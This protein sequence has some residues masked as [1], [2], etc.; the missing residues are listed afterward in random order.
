MQV[1]PEKELNVFYC[2]AREDQSL[3]QKLEQHLSNLKRLYHL[4]TWFDR[5]ILPGDNWAE[6]IEKN[7][8]SADLILLLISPDFMAS[9]YCYSQEMKRA[10]TRHAQG[11]VR[12]IPILLRPVHW[13][14]A[15]FSFIQMLPKDALPVTLWLNLDEAFYDIVL[16]IEKVI[17]NLLSAHETKEVPGE[18]ASEKP[19]FAYQAE[20]AI[21]TRDEWIDEGD[22]FYIAGQYE[23]ALSSY[24]Q[25]NSLASEDIIISLKKGDTLHKLE[26]Y[27]EA[28]QAYAQ[29]IRLSP[30]LAMKSPYKGDALID[31]QVAEEAL[32]LESDSTAIYRNKISALL[33]LQ[34][35][36]EALLVSEQITRPNFAVIA[37]D[38]SNKAYALNGLKRYDQALL[39]CE[40]AIRLKPRL[41]IAYK[42]KAYT[43][44][45]LKRY[46]E[47]LQACEQVIQLNPTLAPAYAIM[48]IVLFRLKSYQEASTAFAQWSEYFSLE[49]SQVQHP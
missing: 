48:G 14:N 40:Q 32:L 21:K 15:P 6:V 17:K 24:E 2:Y 7:L 29:A 47:A 31:L 3:S 5:Q 13:K 10:L 34:R 27:R 42:N 28:I 16:G 1:S 49:T 44:N 43:L 22:A 46:E 33:E 35:Y 26:R 4:N 8:N 37:V 30:Y 18:K 20:E 23:Q 25:A 45:G 9:D 39:A 41:A 11:E 12:V 19:S 38:Y 36:E